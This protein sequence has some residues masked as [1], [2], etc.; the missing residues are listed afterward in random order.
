MPITN[1]SQSASYRGTR[2]D[3]KSNASVTAGDANDGDAL[4]GSGV[5]APD[6]GTA[7]RTLASLAAAPAPASPDLLSNGLFNSASTPSAA[8]PGDAA[9]RDAEEEDDDDDRTPLR[10]SGV[11]MK[12]VPASR[13]AARHGVRYCSQQS[14]SCRS[15]KRGRLRF[16]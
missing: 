8:L 11:G 9:R 14:T 5:P 6:G 3:A 13:S 1:G 7:M 2:P 10:C 15:K 4:S 12:D 16:G